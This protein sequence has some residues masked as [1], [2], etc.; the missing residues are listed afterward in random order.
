MQC[1]ECSKETPV[2]SV[3]CPFCA[4]PL[5]DAPTSVNLPVDEA[6]TPPDEPHV[7]PEERRH[8]PQFGDPSGP[9][10]DHR[11]RDEVPRPGIDRRAVDYTVAVAMHAPPFLSCST[12]VPK[13]LP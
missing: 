4:T 8:L 7:P 9:E 11:R 5:D 6:P 3:V 12:I 1:P 13:P 10:P 2:G